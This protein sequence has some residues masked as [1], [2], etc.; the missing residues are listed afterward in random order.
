MSTQNSKTL[1]VAYRKWSLIRVEPKGVSFEK[2]SRH[3]YFIED[4]YNF[5][6]C[7]F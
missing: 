3:N 5:I 1:V 2:R 7:N 6:A 4:N